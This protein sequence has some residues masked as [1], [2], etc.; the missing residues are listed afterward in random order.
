LV[1]VTSGVE[2]VTLAVSVIVVGLATTGATAVTV[3]VAL[4]P[5]AKV[6]RAAV[7]TPPATEQVPM[8]AVQATVVSPAGTVFVIVVFAAAPRP[9][10]STCMRYLIPPPDTAEEGSDPILITRSA[11]GSSV[12]LLAADGTWLDEPDGLVAIV[13]NVPF[14]EALNVTPSVATVPAAL[15]EVELTVTAAGLKA[16]AKEKVAPVRFEPLTTIV[17]LVGI[18]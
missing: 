18:G 13:I 17:V 3:A 5:A 6:P 10:F 14:A 16:G 9:E 4:V 12:R 7:T 15:T 11:G 8:D 1:R 2:V